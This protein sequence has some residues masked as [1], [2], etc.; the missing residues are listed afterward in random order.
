MHI[1]DTYLNSMTSFFNDEFQ[2]IGEYLDG[3]SV[4]LMR[5]TLITKITF[6]H[7]IFI[8]HLCEKNNSITIKT[9]SSITN[10]N[11]FFI[12]FQVSLTLILI[13]LKV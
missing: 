13:K 4:L 10:F 6:D 3:N 8:S 5:C 7:R 12:L 11:V 1:L 9:K 2:T